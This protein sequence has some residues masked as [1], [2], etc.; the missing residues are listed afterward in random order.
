MKGHYLDVLPVSEGKIFGVVGRAFN[1]QSE[2][3]VK[4]I[5]E[6]LVMF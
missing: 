6:W 2:F 1:E 3:P 5:L 4:E